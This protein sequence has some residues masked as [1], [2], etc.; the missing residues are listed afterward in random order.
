MP[1]KGDQSKQPGL[2]KMDFG[3]RAEPKSIY[4][5]RKDVLRGACVPVLIS[6]LI[7]APTALCSTEIITFKTCETLG[8]IGVG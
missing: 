3:G 1:D 8:K 5:A 6:S 2:K 4:F 7:R